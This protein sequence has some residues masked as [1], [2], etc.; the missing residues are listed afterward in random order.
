ML[1]KPD[2]LSSELDDI[3]PSEQHD[4]FGTGH[5]LANWT[6]G[7]QILSSILIL[8]LKSAN[9]GTLLKNEGGLCCP[10]LSMRYLSYMIQGY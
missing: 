5:L 9:T 8:K 7:S 10:G 6:S 4:V 2:E 3:R 1:S